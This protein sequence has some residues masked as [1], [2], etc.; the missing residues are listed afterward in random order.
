MNQSTGE[1]RRSSRAW[2]FW[3]AAAAGLLAVVALGTTAGATFA[4][5]TPLQ[6]SARSE[7]AVFSRWGD[8]ASYFRISNG[9]FE[10]G[11]Y[12]WSLSGG[13]TVVYGNEPWKV[14]ASTDAYSLKIP[15]TGYAESRTICVTRGEDKIRLFAYN[16]KVSG[17]IL[18]I[19][20]WVQNPDTGQQASYAFD[21][22][23]DASPAGWAPTMVLP[24]PNLLGGTGTQYL[25]FKVTTRGTA[26][27]WLIDDVYV[28]PFK[29][30]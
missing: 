9:G 22:N 24:L 3:R 2:S 18:H 27:T 12:D 7:A 28:D 8:T 6:C 1:A 30:Y 4:F 21:V 26:A 17:A 20:T 29:Q 11:A 14:A 16:P 25:T 13:A 5:G 10:S 23:A 19:E 15:A